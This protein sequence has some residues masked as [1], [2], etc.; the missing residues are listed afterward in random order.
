MRPAALWARTRRFGVNGRTGSGRGRDGPAGVV[1]DH[2]EELLEY[3]QRVA[4][5]AVTDGGRT[6]QARV[7][8]D[9]E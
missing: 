1:V 3:Q 9:L 7:G 5:Q 2:A 6:G 8:R 4:Q